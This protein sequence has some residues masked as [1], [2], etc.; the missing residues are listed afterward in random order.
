MEILQPLHWAL[1]PRCVC[2]LFDIRR[3]D[4][5]QPTLKNLPLYRKLASKVP[6]P[7]PIGVISKD[8]QILGSIFACFKNIRIFKHIFKYKDLAASIMHLFTRLEPECLTRWLKAIV[9]LCLISPQ[10]GW[11]AG[12]PAGTVISNVATVSYS[13][14]GSVNPPIASTPVTFLIDELILP[15]L[16]WQDAAAVSVNSPGINDA[17]TFLLTNGGNGPEVYGLA[18]T[19]GPLPLPAGNYTPKDGSSGSIYFENGLLAGF[20]AVGPNADTAYVPGVNDPTLAPDAG[21][22][23]YVISDTPNVANNLHGDVRLTATSLTAGAAGAAPGT[24]LAGSGQGG[25][26]AVVGTSSA[27][28]SATGSYVTNGL[29]LV[30]NK[31]VTGVLDPRGTAVVMPG[32]VMTYQIEVVLSG[33]GTA[34]NLMISDPLPADITYVPG[35]IVV[36]GTP[37]TDAADA[38]N[39]QF[40]ANTVSVSLGNV[41]APAN[42][43]ITFRATIN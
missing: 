33:A 12:T 22:I 13:I 17:L 43:V 26:Y 19:N 42:V 32:A 35:S 2:H 15:V 7:P 23:I 1:L 3:I 37:R 9:C 31:S 30:V 28:A 39:A 16:T 20:Q 11:A 41:A 25:V 27:Q 21:Q 4:I 6:C 29:G 5:R 8:N 38:D 36:S 14:G 34:S 10:I 24:S 18:R 40:A